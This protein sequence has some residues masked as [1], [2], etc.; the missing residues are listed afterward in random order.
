MKAKLDHTLAF[1]LTKQQAEA[2][3]YLAAAEGIPVS[4]LLRKITGSY[5]AYIGAMSAPQRVNGKA[6]HSENHV[7]R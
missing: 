2:L 5:L 4:Q 6:D 1:C 3:E 7:T